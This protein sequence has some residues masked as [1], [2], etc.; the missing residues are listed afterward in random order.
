MLHN[1][2]ITTFLSHSQVS[3]SPQNSFILSENLRHTFWSSEKLPFL[4]AGEASITEV[5]ASAFLAFISDIGSYQQLSPRSNFRH[6]SGKCEGCPQVRLRLD[7]CA[8]PSPLVGMWL[9]APTSLPSATRTKE[10]T[11]G[12]G[13][14]GELLEKTPSISPAPQSSVRKC[15]RADIGVM[16][17][18]RLPPPFLCNVSRRGHMGTEH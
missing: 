16:R 17:C 5:K 15:L 13:H 12:V 8:S 6:L 10:S 4:R 2:H 18:P 14:R 9:E 3:H 1:C 7:M 11:E